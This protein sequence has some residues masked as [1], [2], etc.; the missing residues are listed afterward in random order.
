MDSSDRPAKPEI[1][2]VIGAME[3]EI[4]SLRQALKVQRTVKRAGMEFVAG[5]LGE[6]SAVVVQCGVGKVNAG[7][8]VQVLADEFQVTRVVNTGAAGALD[9]RLH[10]G[11][12]VIS[13]DAV[14]H[15]FDITT[16][17]FQKGEIPYTG[18]FS[19]VADEALRQKA[20]EAAGNLK[21][22]TVIEGRICSGD[23]FIASHTQKDAIIS[24][25][26]GA[27]CEMEGGAIAQACYLNDIPFVIIRSISD[28]ADEEGG[29]S[30][31]EF[32]KLAAERGAA[33]VRAMLA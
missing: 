4:A 9:P 12:L 19:F 2:G 28:S 18:L 15:D 29:M 32:S 13:T 11:D 31:A 33:L 25:F 21:D 10:I 23:A 14:Q 24:A 27:C 8:C 22:I 16:L 5:T 30:F 20:R 26:G 7:I 3:Q 1:T 17:G 6:E